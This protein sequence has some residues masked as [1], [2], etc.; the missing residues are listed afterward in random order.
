MV[1]HCILSYELLVVACTL[2]LGIGAF[3]IVISTTKEIKHILSLINQKAQS[4]QCN[5]LN[6]MKILITEC[7]VT[8]GIAKQL[9]IL[10]CFN[11]D[12]TLWGRKL[13]LYDLRTPCA[14][15]VEVQYIDFINSL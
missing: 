14:G 6:E 10:V 13:Q 8:Y 4:N 1:E 15:L 7:V 9:S 2:G 12:G 3:C 11:D 5:Q